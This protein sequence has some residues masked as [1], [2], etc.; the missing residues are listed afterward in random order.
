MAKGKKQE[1]K[2]S[3]KVLK[4]AKLA[5]VT[6]RISHNWEEYIEA[7]AAELTKV[8]ALGLDVTKTS[9]ITQ[10]MLAGVADFEKKHNLKRR[11]KED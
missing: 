11:F 7:V 6:I 2:K 9:V 10:L 1:I 4:T 3:P 5:T 8:N